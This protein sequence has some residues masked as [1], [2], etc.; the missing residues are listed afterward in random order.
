MDEKRIELAVR[1]G[2]VDEPTYL[3]GT[4]GRAGR[5][6]WSLVAV[7]AVAALA[8]VVG[9]GLGVGLGV[10]RAPGSGTGGPSPDPEALAAAL[11]GRWTGDEISRETW[12]SDL[13]ALGHDIDDIDN[14]LLHDPIETSTHYELLFDGNE[15][16][17]AEIADGGPVEFLSTGPYEILPDGRFT[18]D[19][20]G[21]RVTAGFRINGDRLAF[22][23]ISTESCGADERVANSA[24]FNLTPYTRAGPP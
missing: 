23:R 10:L 19:D 20:L 12:V 14:F 9:L 17:V 13:R 8:L 7:T 2:P 6:G 16:V 5:R 21:C 3:P 1:E 15:L 24:F 18:W 11:K 22:E 4:F